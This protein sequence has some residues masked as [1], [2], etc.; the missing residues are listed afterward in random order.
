MEE[1]EGE[2]GR[3]GGGEDEGGGDGE[4]GGG[5]RRTFQRCYLQDWMLAYELAQ[6]SQNM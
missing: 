1:V 5:K 4:G 3:G 2:G 6:K